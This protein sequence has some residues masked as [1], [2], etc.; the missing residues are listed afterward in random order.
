VICK[1]RGH[2]GGQPDRLAVV[3]DRVVKIAADAVRLASRREGVRDFRIEPDC[4]V[5]ICYGM[6]EIVFARVSISAIKE[7][8]GVAGIKLGRLPVVRYRAIARR[9]WAMTGQSL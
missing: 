7:S 4:F 1:G 9:D 8:V 6:H 3:G 5:I 2:R